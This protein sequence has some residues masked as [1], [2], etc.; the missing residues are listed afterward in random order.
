MTAATF[1][2]QQFHGEK[3]GGDGSGEGCGHASGSTG[4]EKRF[5]FR[6]GEVKELRDHGA[7]RAA[8]HDDRT[9]RAERAAGTDGDRRRNG[10]QQ[11]DFGLDAAAVHQ[12]GFDGFG[13]TVAADAFGAVP[14][15][16]ADDE[17]AGNGHEQAE[18]TKMIAGWRNEVGA[19]AAEVKKVGEKAD[20]PEKG[21]R[22]ERAKRAD[23]HRQKGNGQN[24]LGHR[25]VAEF[26][27]VAL[28]A[29]C[30]RRHTLL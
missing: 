15:H 27:I 29:Y 2:E 18:H 24:S 21:E 20:E 12:Y 14:S 5:A 10:F 30:C 17:R 19:P 11:R 6:G 1:E 26:V 28:R 25:E 7:E 4:H 9:F 8:G 22:N 23:T 13:D 3:N 16:D